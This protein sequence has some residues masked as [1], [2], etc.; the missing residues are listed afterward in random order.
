M[1]FRIIINN[2]DNNMIEK[3]FLSDLSSF[4]KEGFICYSTTTIPKS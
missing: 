4:F 3:D 2:M 1:A